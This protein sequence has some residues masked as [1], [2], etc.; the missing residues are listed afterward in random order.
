MATILLAEDDTEVMRA[1]V[2]LLSSCGY[3]II[4]AENGNEALELLREYKDI[5]DLVV[6]DHDMN[7]VNGLEVLKEVRKHK[8]KEE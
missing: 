3:H 6:S 5:I 7:P 8:T 4:E 2:R 1:V